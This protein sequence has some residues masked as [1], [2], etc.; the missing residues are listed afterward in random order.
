MAVSGDGFG[1]KPETLPVSFLSGTKYEHLVSGMTGGVAST[2][3]THP[4]DLIKLRFA[5]MFA[6]TVSKTLV[7]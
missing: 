2:L 5:G 6:D 3:I 1:K 4:F 7:R